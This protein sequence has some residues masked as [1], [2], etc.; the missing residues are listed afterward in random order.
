MHGQQN[1]KI[2]LYLLILGCMYI[3]GR[4]LISYLMTG[5]YLAWTQSDAER[6]VG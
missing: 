3:K 4:P 1:I 6:Q 5:D 2:W